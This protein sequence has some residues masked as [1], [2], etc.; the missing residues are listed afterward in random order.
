MSW[1]A[2]MRAALIGNPALNSLIG[3]NLWAMVADSATTTPYAVYQTFSTGGETTHDGDRSLE[4]PNVQI[5]AWATT[6]TEVQLVAKRITR[7]LEGKT[8]PGSSR[9]SFQFSD[10]HSSYDET[11]KLFGEVLE[12]TAAANITN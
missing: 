2:D 9:V 11:T 3:A 8:L 12:F 10:Q 4:F 5:T 1:Q 6:D 7:T